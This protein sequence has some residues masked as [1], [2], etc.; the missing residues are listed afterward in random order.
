MSRLEKF[1]NNNRSEF[2][3]MVPSEQLWQHVEA[4]ITKKTGKRFHIGPFI[5]WSA[6]AAILVMITAAVFFAIAKKN[7]TETAISKKDT[8]VTDLAALAPEEAQEMNQFAKMIVVKQEELKVLAK[9]QP[10]LYQKFAKDI[11]QLDSSYNTLKNKLS[12]TPNRDMLIEAMIQNLELQLNIL[13][14][15]LNIIHQIK[16]TKKYSHEK[17]Q[18]FT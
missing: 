11:T 7:P 16:Q 5:K 1:I 6:A 4:A 2:D 3:D 13:N 9:E 17:N 8:V 15:Q 14:Q 10:L 12:V 18:S